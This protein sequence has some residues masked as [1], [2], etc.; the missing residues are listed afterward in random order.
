MLT[1][2]RC[3]LRNHSDRVPGS[4]EALA[5]Q[6]VNGAVVAWAAGPSELASSEGR[7]GAHCMA[8]PPHSLPPR[9]HIP[10]SDLP[11]LQEL[12]TLTP[13]ETPAL[14]EVVGRVGPYLVWGRKV[15]EKEAHRKDYPPYHGGR[16]H[17][18]LVRLSSAS[19]TIF[20][21]PYGTFQMC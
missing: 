10:F 18:L 19:A 2:S 12:L 8:T 11:E 15:W 4:D 13:R 9:T 1:E 5:Q 6:G 20:V 3:L 17:M 14:G 21:F 7:K 16:G